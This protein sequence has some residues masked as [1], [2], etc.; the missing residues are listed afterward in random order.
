MHFLST[1][2]SC[3]DAWLNRRHAVS[4][5][6]GKMRGLT[7]SCCCG[8]LLC[9]C[10]LSV[11]MLNIQTDYGTTQTNFSFGL[12]PLNLHA[13]VFMAYMEYPSSIWC[14]YTD[15]VSVWKM[16][17]VFSLVSLHPV[18]WLRSLQMEQLCLCVMTHLKWKAA[19]V[20]NRRSA[21]KRSFN[22]QNN[23]TFLLCQ[24]KQKTI[25]CRVF[26]VTWK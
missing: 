2:I 5:A 19:C 17:P 22:I 24:L 20:L 8:A 7:D 9:A 6:A 10:Y 23:I 4:H 26:C 11:L 18:I 15:T 12:R 13:Q 14:D 16:I 21:F 25:F 1:L 3:D